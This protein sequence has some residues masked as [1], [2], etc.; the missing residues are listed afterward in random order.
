MELS[1]SPDREAA[2][3]QYRARASIYDYELAFAESIRRRSVELLR[4]K[5]GEKPLCEGTLAL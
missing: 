4:L 1:T 3:S 2:L 5:R